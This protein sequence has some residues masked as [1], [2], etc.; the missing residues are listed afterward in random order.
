MKLLLLLLSGIFLG[1][2]GIGTRA[3]ARAALED[4]VGRRGDCPD[5]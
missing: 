2:V 3:E 1:I 4:F 5:D